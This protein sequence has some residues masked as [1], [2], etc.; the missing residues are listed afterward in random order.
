MPGDLERGFEVQ[1][2]V[3]PVT[4]GVLHRELAANG[5]H[6]VRVVQD[7]LT[8]LHQPRCKFGFSLGEFPGGVRISGI[9]PGSGSQDKF[10]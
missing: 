3:D 2:G 7:S 1:Q 6:R 10:Q 4:H 5:V 8:Q 9:D